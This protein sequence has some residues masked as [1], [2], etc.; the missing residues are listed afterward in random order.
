[1]ITLAALT[2]SLAVAVLLWELGAPYMAM[3]IRIK[4]KKS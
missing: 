2:S 1:L 3:R 4:S